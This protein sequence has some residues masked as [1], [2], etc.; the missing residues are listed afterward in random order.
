MNWYRR[1]DSNPHCLVPKTSAS[2]RLGYAGMVNPAGLEPATCRLGNDCSNSA[3]LRVLRLVAETGLEPAST[4]YESVPGG[5]T[6]PVYSASNFQTGY[7]GRIRTYVNEF[8]KLAPFQLGHSVTD[9]GSRIAE[10]GLFADSRSR[11]I[12]NPNF[13]IRNSLVDL[14]R[15]ERATSTFAESRSHSAELQ[16]RNFPA[17]SELR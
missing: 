4:D 2:S 1:R 8:Q 5:F 3:E 13:A 9:F 14:A 16:V 10:C 17:V 12:R 6:T 11:S 15:F 7:G